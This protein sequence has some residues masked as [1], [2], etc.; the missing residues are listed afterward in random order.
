ME[1]SFYVIVQQVAVL[2]IFIAVGF[3]CTKCKFFS[4]KSI[5][6]L[7]KFVLYI[8]IPCVIINSFNREYDSSMLRGLGIAAAIAVGVH[9]FGII[10]AQIFIH[11]KNKSRE[12]ILR[13]STVFS[14]CGFMALPLQQA[15]LGDGGVFYCASYIVVFNIVSWTYGL[16]I[17]SGSK[18]GFSI[19][20]I[21]NPGVIGVMLGGLLFASP[22]KLPFVLN[23]ALKGISALNTPVPMIIVGYYIAGISSL[24]VLRDLKFISAMFLRLVVIPFVF[25]GVVKIIGFSGVI[26]T[27]MIIAVSCPVAVNIAMFSTLFKRD[28]ELAAACV[29]VS[30]LLSILTLPLI[31]VLSL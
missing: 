8:V 19:K 29:A 25:L 2:F 31:I 16:F 5:S 11:D 30:T 20:M 27:S 4:E 24:R 23:E 1:A 14:N 28:S 10:L 13:F 18:K 15:I 26:A 17:M 7:S 3:I 9:V 22:V 12:C 6:D 21:V